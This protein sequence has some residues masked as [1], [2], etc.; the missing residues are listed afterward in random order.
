LDGLNRTKDARV[1]IEVRVPEYKCS[2]FDVAMAWILGVS[3][4]VQFP[5]LVTVTPWITDHT[6]LGTGHWRCSGRG[7]QEKLCFPTEVRLLL[8]G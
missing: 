2:N 7:G 8:V 3:N 5:G 6:T 4:D 1:S